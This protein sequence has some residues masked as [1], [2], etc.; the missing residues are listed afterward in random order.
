MQFKLDK[1]QCEAAKDFRTK[2]IDTCV[3]HTNLTLGEYFAYFFIPTG[4]GAIARIKCNVC[5]EELDLT[6]YDNW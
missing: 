3:T 5:G 4:L 1:K 6:D 2:H